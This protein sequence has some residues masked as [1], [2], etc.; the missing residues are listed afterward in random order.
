MMHDFIAQPYSGQGDSRTLD[1][2]RYIG[3]EVEKAA[4]AQYQTL[5][6]IL[7][8]PQADDTLIQTLE[9]RAR[10]AYAY[11]HSPAFHELQALEA[12]VVLA[13]GITQEQTLQVAALQPLPQ[14]RPLA[15][16][17]QEL[18]KS[19]KT[20]RTFY[21][22]LAKQC[23]KATEKVIEICNTTCIGELGA[24]WQQIKNAGGPRYIMVQK[25][26]SRIH[27]GAY[28]MQHRDFIAMEKRR[29]VQHMKDPT[30]G[31]IKSSIDTIAAL[32]RYLTLEGEVQANIH[33]HATEVEREKDPL[34]RPMVR[35]AD[36][37]TDAMRVA[38]L[39]DAMP[40][41]NILLLEAHTMVQKVE[42]DPNLMSYEELV[43][44]LRTWCNVN[45]PSVLAPAATL[46]GS[47]S[48]VAAASTVFTPQDFAAMTAQAVTR[49]IQQYQQQQQGGSG[50]GRGYATEWTQAQKIAHRKTMPCMNWNGEQGSCTKS[51]CDY[52]HVPGVNQQ[53]QHHRLK[54]ERSRSRSPSQGR[55][56]QHKNPATPVMSRGNKYGPDSNANF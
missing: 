15:E 4:F 18:L 27:G 37:D 26:L 44:H 19:L 50:S 40:K 46:G 7:P 2:R 30:T 3:N 41:D 28:L 33:H 17:E 32:D 16:Q 54:R 52:L 45:R 38:M 12:S 55:N 1:Y 39:Y 49:G 48:T 43:R 14:Q 34:G 22:D 11:I 23:S 25:Y 8:N 10:G 36:A 6:Y 29:I 5:G 42:R 24:A 13:G 31:A 35:A 20:D 56:T 21:V 51:S 53:E 9:T 47:S